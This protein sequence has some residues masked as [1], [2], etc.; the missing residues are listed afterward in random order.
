MMLCLQRGWQN[1]IIPSHMPPP[2]NKALSYDV[3]ITPLLHASIILPDT[4]TTATQ[5]ETRS[6]QITGQLYKV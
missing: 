2:S 5:H 1:M 3:L 6:C 4:Y